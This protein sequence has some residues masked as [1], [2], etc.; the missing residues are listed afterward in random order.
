M[1][2]FRLRECPV[3]QILRHAVVLDIEKT[4]TGSGIQN[5]G[6]QRLQGAVL[7]TEIGAQ[8]NDRQLRQ[9]RIHIPR[10]LLLK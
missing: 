5:L 4:N 1:K 7:A 8:I 2:S 6:R 3:D 10:C 9:R